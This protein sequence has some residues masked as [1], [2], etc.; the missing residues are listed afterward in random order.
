VIVND[1]AGGQQIG[2]TTGP[3]A[4]K[5][6]KLDLTLVVDTTGSMGDEIRYLQS[7]LQAILSSIESRHRDLDIRVGFVFYRDEGD[8]Y[9]TRTIGFD[10]DF[11]RAQGV[12]ARQ[13][14][15]GGGDYPEA[16]DQAMIR[17]MNL[18]WRA[19]A[20][21]SLLLVADAPP[22]NEQFG[23]TWKAAEVARA[24]RV[25]ITPLA[26]SGVAG[27]AEY[28]MRAM[29]ALTQSRYLFLTDDSGVGNPHAPPAI[30]CYLVTRLDALVR[31]VIDS[32]ISGRRI[33][34]DDGEVIRSVGK[35]DAGK[36]VLPS[37]FDR[38]Q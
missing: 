21:K 14:A 15:T 37:D 2:I 19:D 12:L 9:V 29:A 31:R 38:Q 36:C 35:Y 32:Q 18:D 24:K 1:G 10:R 5:V 17:A 16:M 30:D 7:E 8:E 27:E 34:P 11:G 26:A 6:R 20:V 3:A 13:V 28:G 33:E 22:H 23:R 4:V 25:H